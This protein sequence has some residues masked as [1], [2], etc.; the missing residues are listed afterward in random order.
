MPARTLPWLLALCATGLPV[1]ATEPPYRILEQA[2]EAPASAVILPSGERGI[3]VVRRC[4]GCAPESFA[5]TPATRYV[6][7]AGPIALA[8]LRA[9]ARAAPDAGLTVLYDARS[10]QV[11][12]VIAGSRLAA[13]LAPGRPRR[14]GEPR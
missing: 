4:G 11:T 7:A 5:T 13:H 6:T 3:L 9:A 12:R 1:A 10:H 2:V 8:D 14:P